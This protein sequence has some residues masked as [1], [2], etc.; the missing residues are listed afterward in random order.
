[1]RKRLLFVFFS[2][3]LFT[4]ADEFGVCLTVT[5]TVRKKMRG[6]TAED[7]FST[8]R[9]FLLVFIYICF[10]NQFFVCTVIFKSG[11]NCYDCKDAYCKKQYS[12][13]CEPKGFCK[14]FHDVS[15]LSYNLVLL[16]TQ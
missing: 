14:F 6:T 13:E 3:F 16:R 7:F 11:L 2:Y 10:P 12:T 8:V 4:I 5:M 1:M 15:P 9:T